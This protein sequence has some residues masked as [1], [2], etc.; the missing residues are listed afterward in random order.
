[1]LYLLDDFFLVSVLGIN[2][3]LLILGLLLNTS[4]RKQT[5]LHHTGQ[6]LFVIIVYYFETIRDT[7]MDLT[8]EFILLIVAFFYSLIVFVSYNNKQLKRRRTS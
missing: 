3:F 6:A 7:Q 2:L 4:F 5:M 1:M 8:L